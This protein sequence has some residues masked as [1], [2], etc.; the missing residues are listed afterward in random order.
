[1]SWLLLPYFSMSKTV[2]LR[3]YREVIVNLPLWHSFL[4]APQSSVTWGFL[5]DTVKPNVGQW[6]LHYL[7]VGCIPFLTI[8]AA[9]IF[10]VYNKIK[11]TK[12]AELLQAII[13]TSFV[14]I[15][16]HV[17]TENGLSLYA[18]IF[19]LPGINSMR[20]LNRFMHVELFLLLLILGYAF[21]TLRKVTLLSICLL[22]FADNCFSPHHIPREMKEDLV[23]RRTELINKLKSHDLTKIKSV[24]LIDTSGQAFVK[25]L[26][27]MLAA[28]SIGLPTINGYS[29]YCPEAFG[30]F[31]LDVSE[32]ALNTWVKSQ[33]LK[34]EEI[35]ILKNN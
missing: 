13:I 1:M 23:N 26:D 30:E 16:L 9:P 8:I 6:W 35:L 15:L 14:I 19:K 3:L 18:L 2:G 11:R 34:P 29:S 32:E 31:F 28:Q 7:F 33:N 27:M 25:H 20:V 10:L 21:L 17:R 22:V 5:H 12:I 4:F 24:A